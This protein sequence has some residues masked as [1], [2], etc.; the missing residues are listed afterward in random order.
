MRDIA[1]LRNFA[2]RWEKDGRSGMVQDLEARI[3]GLVFCDGEGLSMEGTGYGIE[4]ALVPTSTKEDP[5]DLYHASLLLSRHAL[6]QLLLPALL[7][8]ATTSSTPIR[9]ISQT[10]PFYSTSPSLSLSDLDYASS[11]FPSSSPWLAEGQ[12][13][14]AAILLFRELQDR[15]ND[16]NLVF[17][18]V[19]AGFTRAWVYRIMRAAWDHPRFSWLGYALSWLLWPLIW[20]LTKSGDA[21]SQGLL[22]A[23]LASTKAGQVPVAQETME[24]EEEKAPLPKPKPEE[25]ADEDKEKHKITLIGGALYREGRIVR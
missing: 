5:L 20:C 18:S 19:C 13:S 22:A 3:D 16:R 23:V 2:K 24:G 12:S 9:I 7:R 6:V 1:S 15:L 14:L 8:S 4:Q 10:S 17:V 11:S 21:A 25:K